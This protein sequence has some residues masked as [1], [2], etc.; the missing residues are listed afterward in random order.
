MRRWGRVLVVVA[1]MAT[2]LAIISPFTNQKIPILWAVVVCACMW[3][4]L[5]LSY[6]EITWQM[7]KNLSNLIARGE[8]I[9]AR[10]TGEG[11]EIIDRYQLLIDEW[12]SQV[13]NVLKGTEY[14]KSWKSNTGLVKPESEEQETDI[15]QYLAVI[16]NYMTLRI[17]RLQ[18]IKEK[19]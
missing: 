16:R 18:E 1:I 11:W 17:T 10:L 13:E 19:L 6:L 2:I 7:K 4:L 12:V 5:I 8:Y 9:L 14:E 3:G 15:K